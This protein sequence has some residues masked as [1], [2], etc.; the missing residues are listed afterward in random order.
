MTPIG[1]TSSNIRRAIAFIVD[2]S[3]R[4]ASARAATRDQVDGRPPPISSPL[5]DFDVLPGGHR[6]VARFAVEV[7][8]REEESP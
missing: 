6:P 5:P 1:S 7:T 3:F 2:R 4:N 8:A